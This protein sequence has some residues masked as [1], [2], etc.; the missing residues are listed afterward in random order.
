MR[1]VDD[2]IHCLIVS[3]RVYL[4]NDH[5]QTNV[6]VHVC[7][8]VKRDMEPNSLKKMKDSQNYEWLRNYKV[9]TWRHDHLDNTVNSLFM[10]TILFNVPWS[11]T[12]SDAN[13]YQQIYLIDFLSFCSSLKRKSSFYFHSFFAFFTLFSLLSFSFFHWY[14]RPLVR[15][16]SLSTAILL[17]S[18]PFFLRFLA[19]I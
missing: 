14:L 4:T 5:F 8:R 11:S 19:F 17:S 13:F 2:H 3:L 12:S 16:I 7:W 6:V 18:F 1:S 9:K 15:S 10:T